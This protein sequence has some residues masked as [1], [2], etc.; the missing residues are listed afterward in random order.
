MDKKNRFVE[1]ILKN[2][3]TYYNDGKNYLGESI[4]GL[5]D[6]I[7]LDS[8]MFDDLVDMVRRKVYQ[9]TEDGDYLIPTV[10]DMTLRLSAKGASF[11]E[12]QDG[13]KRPVDIDGA[14]KRTLLDMLS[15]LEAHTEHGDVNE[16]KN[17]LFTK[18]EPEGD[19]VGDSVTK[20]HA[21]DGVS[22]EAVDNAIQRAIAKAKDRKF[23]H[24]T[25]AEAEEEYNDR[26]NDPEYREKGREYMQNRRDTMAEPHGYG[27]SGTGMLF[28]LDELTEGLEEISRNKKRQ[29]RKAALD[30]VGGE[31]VDNVKTFCI[32][33][34]ENPMGQ[35]SG[36]ADN[37][38][39]NKSINSYL[40]Q[41]NYAW[42][43]VRG[44]YGNTENSKIIFNISLDEAKRLGVMFQQESFIFGRKEGGKTL[45]DLYMINDTH[46]GYNFVETQE[47]S[48][49]VGDEQNDF[50]TAIGKNYK[51]NVPFEYF[52]E[53]CEKFNSIINEAKEK[54]E[55]YRDNYPRSLN[56]SIKDGMTG[57]HYFLHRTLMYGGLF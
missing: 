19:S 36:R 7:K 44:K 5:G 52:K 24:E 22:R 16:N 56:E 45:F 54:S 23:Q 8:T 20:W 25:D 57:N 2:V 3:G 43:P 46:D 9:R 27:T 51:F 40:E 29:N 30:A 6:T 35:S 34:G 49:R 47:K 39:A 28:N 14:K 32:I 11:L 13:E 12:N 55:S 18:V 50:Y 17:N 38:R 15:F 31:S 37:R 42:E 53:A 48:E 10:D 4:D 1:N 26:Y 41:G 21:K 33:T